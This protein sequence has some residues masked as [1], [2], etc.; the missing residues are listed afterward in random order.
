[1]KY[2]LLI[3]SKEADWTDAEREQCIQDSAKICRELDSKRQYL[4]A[5]PLL[6]VATATSIRLRQGK[7]EVIDGPFAE[8][9]E[10][11]GGYFLIDVANLDEAM[12]IAGRLPG[13]QRG[14][15][16]IRPIYDVPG[17]PIVKVE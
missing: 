15:V 7:R 2:L 13:V 12:E 16:E 8:T 5:S 10:Q 1:M 9:T 4:S 14:T 3:Y 17:L 11:L 6:P